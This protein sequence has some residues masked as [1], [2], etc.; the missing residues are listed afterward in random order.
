MELEQFKITVIPLREKLLNYSLKVTGEK[1]DA[2]DIVQEAFL[3]LWYMRNKLDEYKS[4]EALAMQ[5]VKNQCIDT[6]RNRKNNVQ[7]D[8]S[9]CSGA[10]NPEAMLEKHDAVEKV[11]CIVEALP[12]LQQIIIRMKDIDGYELEEIARIT[13]TQIE[14]VRM[15]L[16]RARKKV[17]EQFLKINR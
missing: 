11:R 6:L 1:A 9:L 3:K 14:A 2:E 13:D 4:V 16:S 8:L 15:N 12:S 17:R 5:M 7:P 10:D